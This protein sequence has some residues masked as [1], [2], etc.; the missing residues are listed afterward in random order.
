VERGGSHDGAEE[1]GSADA[2]R[3]PGVLVVVEEQVAERGRGLRHEP[4]CSLHLRVRG[5][6]GELAAVQ[7]PA[8][9]R[10]RE[11]VVGRRAL[12]LHHLVPRRRGGRR[13]RRLVL[14]GGWFRLG[15]GSCKGRGSG[16]EARCSGG[17]GR[18]GE[19]WGQ[20][21]GRHVHGMGFRRRRSVRRRR[22]WR[23]GGDGG[24]GFG[25]RGLRPGG[26][27][28][29]EGEETNVDVAVEII[30]V[31]VFGAGGKVGLGSPIG[32]GGA[33]HWEEQGFACGL[34]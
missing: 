5:P 16:A 33:V 29:Q 10:G 27:E 11:C 26:G 23:R 4:E 3:L 31:L 12:R 20:G 17:D 15:P 19:A 22:G 24:R 7:R 14:R 8:G 6:P 2:A 32:S 1:F 25:R 9:W 28:R 18:Q 21:F 30:A 34:G 13:P